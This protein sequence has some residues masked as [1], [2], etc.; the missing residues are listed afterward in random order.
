MFMGGGYRDPNNPA[1]PFFGMMA[2]IM[3]SLIYVF[4]S[5]NFAKRDRPRF[6]I[7][8]RQVFDPGSTHL[9]YILFPPKYVIRGRFDGVPAYFTTYT[10][11]RQGG[12]QEMI[13]VRVRHDLAIKRGARPRV[14]PEIMTALSPML[15]LPDFDGLTLRSGRLPFYAY[16]S[17]GRPTVF[18]WGRGIH[19][20]RLNPGL[21]PA[22]IRADFELLLQSAHE[23]SSP[24]AS[25]GDP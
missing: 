24:S 15:R 17:D 8:A 16:L 19:L 2:L 20:S 18:G 25:V 12:R 10:N 14:S 1:I 11:G 9:H 4:G 23:M 21:D 6:E 3:F 7:L 22:D 5:Y 13:E